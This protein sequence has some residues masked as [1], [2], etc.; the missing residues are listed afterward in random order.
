MPTDMGYMIWLGIH[1]NGAVIGMT[2]SITMR[3]PEKIRRDLAVAITKSSAA[4]P[5]TSVP[6]VFAALIAPMT[7]VT[8]TATV[9]FVAS[10]IC[11]LGFVG[12]VG[13]LNKL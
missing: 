4:A 9:A 13:R 7:L 12:V 11:R 10:G 2:G 6:R 8:S 5:G 3:A 1:G